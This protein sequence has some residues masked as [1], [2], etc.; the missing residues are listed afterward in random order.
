VRSRAIICRFGS[1]S[2]IASSW[3]S[4]TTALTVRKVTGSGA[5][6]LGRNSERYTSSASA[7]PWPEKWWANT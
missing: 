2:A 5:R 3:V 4:A 6:S 1:I 7:V